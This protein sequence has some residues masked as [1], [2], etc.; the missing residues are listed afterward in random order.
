MATPQQRKSI[1]QEDR[2][3]LARHAYRKTQIDSIQTTATTYNVPRTTLQTLVHGFPPYRGS[4][5]VNH[6]LI[7]TEEEI[8]VRWILDMIIAGNI[9][10]EERYLYC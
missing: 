6:L 10:K 3:D 4:H 7:I 5:T 1:Y 8:L 2:L 9:G